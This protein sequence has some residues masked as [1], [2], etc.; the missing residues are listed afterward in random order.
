MSGPF[1]VQIAKHLGAHVT[2][3]C[4]TD[5]VDLVRSLGAD[6]VIDYRAVDY[7]TAAERYD[8]ILAVEAHHSILRV[9]RV[10]RSK[11]VYVTLGGTTSRLFQAMLTGPVVSLATG[12]SMGLML[13][14]KPFK[15][16]D[17]AALADLLCGG[18]AQA[19]HRPAISPQRDRRGAA[20]RRRR[21][22]QGQGRHHRLRSADVQG[23]PSTSCV[24]SWKSYRWSLSG[25]VKMRSGRG[26]RSAP[27]YLL[28]MNRNVFTDVNRS[29]RRSVMP[30][31]YI[32]L[33]TPEPDLEVLGRRVDAID[34]LARERA[35]V[36]L[37][38]HDRPGLLGAGEQLARRST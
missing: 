19:G 16:E 5:K 20:L 12:K 26:G 30:G 33:S 21:P 3:V 24:T 10:L 28:K 32:A 15:A 38:D 2:A 18:R 6:A 4:S 23:V 17:V 27:K 11:G 29:G 35:F 22:R 34:A 1:A 8:W 9:R 14:W 25:H 37:D 36:R 31:R 13:W 7:T